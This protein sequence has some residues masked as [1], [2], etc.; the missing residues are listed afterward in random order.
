[1]NDLTYLYSTLILGAV[2]ALLLFL[3]YRSWRRRGLR[4]SALMPSS[5]PLSGETLAS[6]ARVFYV[7]TTPADAQLERIAVP[8]L[9]YRGWATLSVKTDGVE[10]TVTGEPTVTIA[11]SEILGAAQ[12]Q[13]TIDKIVEHDGLSVLEWDSE[14]GSLVSSF[15]FGTTQEQQDFA[16][17]IS[18]ML[19]HQP[20]THTHNS[21]K[22]A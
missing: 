9:A 8:G 14:R 20:D 19:G 11:Q 12:A 3:M 7:A 16:H 10:I 13:L 2:T 5:T 22:E 4:D 21:T 18:R 17:S 6:F 15:R 1:M